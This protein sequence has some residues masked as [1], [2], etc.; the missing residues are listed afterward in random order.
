MKRIIVL[1]QNGQLAKELSDIST[2]DAEFICLGRDKIDI[3]ETQVIED[4]LIELA[5][6]AIINAAAYTAVDQAETDKSAAYMLNSEAVGNL[7]LICRRNSFH[8]THVSTDFVFDG[9]KSS[10]YI[11]ED[12]V[13]PISVYG[14]SKSEGEL[15]LRD[16]YPENSCIIRTSWVY[17]TY[18]NNFVKTIMRLLAERDLLGIVS[19]QVGTPTYAK[20]LAFVCYKAALKSL[21]G[22]YH[23]TDAGVAS[24]YDFAVAIQEIAMDKGLI[25][26]KTKIMPINSADYP[27]AATR[28][29]FSVL[30][31]QDILSEL[32]EVEQVHWR[33]NLTRMINQLTI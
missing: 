7:A 17:S 4:K 9:Q 29:T 20:D 31:K 10:P 16:C 24:W 27:T 3:C 13:N 11:P 33:R 12:S 28:P 15:K 22:I 23:W 25:E 14:K 21:K 8:L 32:P 1:G 30:D 2:Q 18:G 19:D 6:D 26:S 5:P